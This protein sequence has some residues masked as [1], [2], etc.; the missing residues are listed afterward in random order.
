MLK[1]GMSIEMY[2]FIKENLHKLDYDLENGIVITPKGTNG[3]LCSSTGYLRVRVGKKVLQVHQILSVIYFG[4]ECIG[5]QINH[6][7]G[8]KLNNKINNLEAI[9]Q[10]DNLK[11]AKDNDLLGE[12]NPIN[13]KSI[14]KL[15]MQGNYICTYESIK[16]ASVDVGLKCTKSIRDALKGVGSKGEKRYSAKGFMWRVTPN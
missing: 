8:N 3:S 7:D 10:L 13:K 5:M 1:N 11:H 16:E 2:N 6:K 9:T 4:E 12:S 15:D 14:D